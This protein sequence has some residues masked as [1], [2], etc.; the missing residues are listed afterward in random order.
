M[1]LKTSEGFCAVLGSTCHCPAG[2]QA[3][4]C[5]LCSSIGSAGLCGPAT[6]LEL[7]AFAFG[8]LLR[9]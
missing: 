1:G 4:Y 2:N 8:S 9:S 3:Q 6:L 7:L 5:F